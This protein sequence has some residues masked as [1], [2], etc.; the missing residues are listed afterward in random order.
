MINLIEACEEYVNLLE[1]PPNN[2]G[3]HIH[4]VHGQS[5]NLL[6]HLY[7]GWGKDEVKKCIDSIFQER[8]LKISQPYKIR[9]N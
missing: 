9:R 4:P 8:K 7:K 1:T 3:Q 6:A 2:W 5:H